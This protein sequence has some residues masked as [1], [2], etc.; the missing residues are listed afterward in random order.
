MNRQKRQVKEPN[1]EILL[2]GLRSIGYEFETAVADIVDNSLGAGA[3]NVDIFWNSTGNNPYFAICDDGIGMS[4]DELDAAM[5]FGTEKVR[6]F[7]NPQDL[8]RYGL[9]LNTASLSQ[10]RCFTVITKR[11]GM[12][13]ASRWDMDEIRKTHDWTLIN[14]T[15]EEIR[16][17]PQAEYLEN[18]NSGTVVIWTDFDKIRE[19]TDNFANTFDKLA[20]SAREYCALVFHRF[21]KKVSI[22]FNGRRVAK[23]DP[24]L[25]GSDKVKTLRP[26]K[27]P[28]KGQEIEVQ[29]FRMPAISDLSNEEKE[30]VGGADSLKSE[31]GIYI[32]RNQRL[33]VW[34]KWMRIEHKTVYSHLAR[35]RIDIPSILDKEWYLDV[36]KSSAT[37]PDAIKKKLYAQINEVLELS[38]RRVRYDGEQEVSNGV[39]RVWVRKMLEDQTVT[40]SLN[41]EHPILKELFEELDSGQRRLLTTYLKD[42]QNYVPTTKMRDDVSDKLDVINGRQTISDTEKREDLVARVKD[43]CQGDKDASKRTLDL[44]L[45]WEQFSDLAGDRDEILEE[46]INGIQ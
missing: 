24:F 10:C 27:I 26:E 19:S 22:T 15:E 17:I 7:T 8:G 16:S 42:V 1:P 45:G 13:S 2:I 18:K 3:E 20:L 39:S 40:Y 11:F 29:A 6:D 43:L 31:Q 37:I 34:G 41:N 36:K 14:L 28:F 33:I 5:D 12:L 25:E 30:L 4:D 23:R 38:V 46:C 32:Y 44:L 9:G 35:V 21:Y